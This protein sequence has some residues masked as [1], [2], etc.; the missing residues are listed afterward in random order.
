MAAE[1]SPSASTVRMTFP[2][3]ETL[4]SNVVVAPVP[5]IEIQVPVGMGAAGEIQVD[6]GEETEVALGEYAELE[7]R[8]QRDFNGARHIHF[9]AD[10]PVSGNPGKG[11]CRYLQGDG[12]NLRV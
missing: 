3:A 10:R 2:Q 6:S 7:Y 12:D 8:D 9:I 11:A 5:G 1:V 4:S